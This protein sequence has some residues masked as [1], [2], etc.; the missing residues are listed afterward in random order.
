[1]MIDDAILFSPMNW[2]GFFLR[3]I[4]RVVIRL[5]WLSFWSS[6]TLEGESLLQPLPF[7]SSSQ[8]VTLV[9]SQPI[10]SFGAFL[11][12]PSHFECQ[13]L[14]DSCRIKH[15]CARQGLLFTTQELRKYLMSF[16]S[17]VMRGTLLMEQNWLLKHGKEEIILF[18]ENRTVPVKCWNYSLR[19]NTQLVRICEWMRNFLSETG[20]CML[21]SVHDIIRSLCC[22]K[23]NNFKREAL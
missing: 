14:S 23:M 7:P 1:M 5:F 8:L 20:S 15:L 18:A 13:P 12:L 22:K 19:E 4:L 16:L 9:K 6:C 10:H 17:T 11:H 21:Q 2:S 3:E